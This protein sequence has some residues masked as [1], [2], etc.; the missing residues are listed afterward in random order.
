MIGKGIAALALAAS[1]VGTAAFPAAAATSY[2]GSPTSADKYWEVQTSGDCVE[3]S[4][5]K[6]VDMVE[7]RSVVSQKAIDLYA[8]ALGIFSP[9]V[10]TSSAWASDLISHYGATFSG[11]SAMSSLRLDT[12]LAKGAAVIVLVNAETLWTPQGYTVAD[13]QTTLAD[14]AVV[15]EAVNKS[16]GAVTLSDGGI[17]TGENEVV[18]WA[19]FSKA[20]ATSGYSAT[21]VTK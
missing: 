10:G 18:S 16:T 3:Q 5:R 1:V 8:E 21:V 15:V 20:W 19:L 13:P 4:V 14:H 6:A 17:P 7:G 11:P 12:D 9:S 2:Y